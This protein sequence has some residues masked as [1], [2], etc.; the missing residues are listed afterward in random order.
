M[1]D[2]RRA[3]GRHGTTTHF[4]PDP[5]VFEDLDFNFDV[6]SQRLRE[7]AYL[8]K[9]VWITLVDERQ[10]PIHE[11]SFYFE[12]GLV[13]FVRHLNKDKETL[14]HRP[15]YVERREGTTNIE[16][17]LQYNDSY[18]ENVFCLRQQHQHGRRR[19]ACDRLPGRPDQLA[20]RLGKAR[21]A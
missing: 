11:K 10:T 19:H 8:N 5:E 7:S 21:Q 17:A 15:I 18:S 9:R 12:G 1:R 4:K 2:L 6:I 16:V 14:H 3:D 20:Q 13:S